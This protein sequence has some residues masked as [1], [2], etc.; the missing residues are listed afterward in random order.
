MKNRK[1]WRILLLGM[2][3][4]LPVSAVPVQAEEYWPEGPQIQAETAIVMEASTGAVLYEKNAHDRG[5]PASTTKVMTSLL[6]VENSGLD[7]DVTFSQD[8]VYKTE[9]SGI[10]RDIGEVMTM[11]EC[12][13]GL[14]LESANECGYA[15]AEHV[16][17]GYDN[18]ID[19]MN[20]KAKELG[21]ADTHFNN[22]HGLPD[23]NH[24]TSVYDLALISREALKNDIF[25]MVVN[26][27][28]Y[29]IPPTNKHSEETYLSNHHKMLNNYKGDEQYLYDYCIGG[30]TGYTSVAGS[31]LL[32]FAEK[33]GMTLICAV[34]K[35][36]APNH[37]I[38]TRT[39]FDY[40]F[41]NFKLWNVAENE[42]NY[43]E[44]APEMK[45]FENEESFVGLNKTGC[46]VLPTAAAF[47]DAVPKVIESKDSDRI[48][49]RI[50][51]TYA[52]RDVGGT[53]IEMTGTKVAEF[54]F[55]KKMDVVPMPE[56]KLIKINVKY[57]VIGVI[58]FILLVGIG[59]GIYHL[60]DNFYLI[61]YKFESRRQQKH[62]FKEIK[63][64]RWGRWGRR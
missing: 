60:A 43:S 16:G 44:D 32:T 12:L 63:G 55:K 11:R 24:W 7:E 58:S 5:Y 64:G 19:M 25:R 9:G 4:L 41:E 50:E 13:Y 26:T 27:K 23:D 40:C 54:K 49:G 17:K 2:I 45:I 39:L 61:R 6:A 34:M 35:E 15:I 53:D 30:K 48:V 18:F 37:Y 29:T 62:K 51:Y 28:R 14:M 52:D 42:K 57:I 8:A 10:S 47:E 59:F 36:T 22:P 31:T 1:R 3:C 33:D 20:R 46:V 56:K 21:C 38:D